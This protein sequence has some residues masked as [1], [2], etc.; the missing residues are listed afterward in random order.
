MS[1]H[2]LAHHGSPRYPPITTQTGVNIKNIQGY[3]YSSLAD[4]LSAP[5]IADISMSFLS[6]LVS[7]KNSYSSMEHSRHR[8]PNYR[9]TRTGSQTPSKRHISSPR[10][11]T[12]PIT[13]MPQR[14]GF[15]SSQYVTTP[16]AGAMDTF[17]YGCNQPRSSI[18]DLVSVFI[19]CITC[20]VIAGMGNTLHKA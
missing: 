14:V 4:I 17:L 16:A 11:M 12:S 19:A 13:S 10:I 2:S 3:M 8:T 5:V 7:W 1:I 15:T 6:G 18:S 9:T 20:L